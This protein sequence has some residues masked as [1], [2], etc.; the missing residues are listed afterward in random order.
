MS[1]RPCSPAVL[2]AAR[3]LN[4][5]IR[6]MSGSSALIVT[7]L[8]DVPSGESALGYMQFI[9]HLCGRLRRVLLIRGT[10]TEVITAFA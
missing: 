9:E 2:N 10:N 7:N 3:I 4:E 6:K 5:K 8:P 1:H